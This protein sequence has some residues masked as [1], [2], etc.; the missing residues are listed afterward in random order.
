[1][2]FSGMITICCIPEGKKCQT[3]LRAA[4]GIVLVKAILDAE[5]EW[6]SSPWYHLRL[7]WMKQLKIYCQQ[8]ADFFQFPVSVIT[9]SFFLQAK[10]P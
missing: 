2:N 1:M 4:V 6:Q 5:K 8:R 7:E 3:R 9:R 10:S